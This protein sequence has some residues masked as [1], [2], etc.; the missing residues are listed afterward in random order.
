[1]DMGKDKIGTNLNVIHY[2]EYDAQT[3][4]KFIEHGEQGNNAL[5]RV[6]K[7]NIRKVLYPYVLS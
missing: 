7:R 5:L 4:M 2:V 1:M 6:V 3:L